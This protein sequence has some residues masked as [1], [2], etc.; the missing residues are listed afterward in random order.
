MRWAEP[1]R[2]LLLWLLPIVLGLLICAARRRARLE[3]DLGAP[4]ALR[5]LTGDPGRG[6]R[7]FRGALLLLALAVAGVGLARPQSG[8]RLVTTTTGLPAVMT[9]LS[10]VLAEASGLSLD[11]VLMSQ[12]I[13]FSNLLFAYEGAPLV[14]AIGYARLPMVQVTK[15]LLVLGAA[16]IAL[17]TPLTYAWWRLLGL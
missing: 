4:S 8:F 17:L 6:P 10:G 11:M 13:G 1:E 16:T 2:L 3:A 15:V 9:P 5:E 7:L 12:T 14:F